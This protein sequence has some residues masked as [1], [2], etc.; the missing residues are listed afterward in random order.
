LPAG[1]TAFLDTDFT[2]VKLGGAGKCG[3]FSTATAYVDVA[4]VGSDRML[5]YHAT[6]G[7]K[8]SPRVELAL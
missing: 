2:G 7:A 8:H 3:L 4:D 6:D 1:A 5:K